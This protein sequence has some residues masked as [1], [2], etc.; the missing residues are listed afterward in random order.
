MHFPNRLAA[1]PLPGERGDWPTVVVAAAPLPSERVTGPTA[2]KENHD[3]L[4]N[5]E[6]CNTAVTGLRQ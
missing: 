1:E 2:G 4:W 5:A 3:S 6:A